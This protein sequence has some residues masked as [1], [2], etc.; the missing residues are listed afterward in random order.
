[1]HAVINNINYKILNLHFYLF[2][3]IDTGAFLQFSAIFIQLEGVQI[4]N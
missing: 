1:M 3:N 4:F 2:Y